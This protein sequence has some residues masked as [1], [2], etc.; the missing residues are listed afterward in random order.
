MLL[1]IAGIA[2][3]GAPLLPCT[4]FFFFFFFTTEGGAPRV[5]PLPPCTF[6][7]F[8]CFFFFFA[9]G[10]P[11]GAGGPP[12]IVGLYPGYSTVLGVEFLNCTVVIYIYIIFNKKYY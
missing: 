1:R 11:R 3:G 12:G 2:G 5:A 4:F 9:A 7:F 8:F 6:F 10:A